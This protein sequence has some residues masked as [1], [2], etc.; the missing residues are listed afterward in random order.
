M[1]FRATIVFEFNAG[2]IEDAGQKV[3]DTVDHAREAAGM[4]AKT[5]DLLTPPGSPAV[6]IPPPAT[7]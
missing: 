3:S 4:D 6:T 7:G 1:K 2:S 5:I